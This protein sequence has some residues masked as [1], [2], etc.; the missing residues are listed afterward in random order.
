MYTI[1]SVAWLGSPLMMMVS[2]GSP[3][4]ILPVFA[5]KS[6]DAEVSMVIRIAHTQYVH[7]VHVMR[8]LLVAHDHIT[9]LI[10]IMIRTP[11][12]WSIRTI[13]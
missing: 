13:T 6:V 7:I 3:T 1:G 4:C 2:V 8:Q 11:A 9:P 10:A 12:V 5:K